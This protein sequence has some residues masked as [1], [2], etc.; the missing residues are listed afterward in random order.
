MPQ[1]T[2]TLCAIC[3]AATERGVAGQAAQKPVSGGSK[4]I[5]KIVSM[6]SANSG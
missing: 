2:P 5:L 4:S 6:P 1:K 3:I